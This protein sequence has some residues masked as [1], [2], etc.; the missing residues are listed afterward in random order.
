MAFRKKRRLKST[1]TTE[2]NPVVTIVATRRMIKLSSNPKA[3][4]T[5][6]LSIHDIISGWIKYAVNVEADNVLTKEYFFMRK[7]ILTESE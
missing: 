4:S 1:Q 3:V 6:S 5:R 7:E 2:I